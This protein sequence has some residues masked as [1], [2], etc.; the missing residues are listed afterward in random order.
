MQL[1]A[2]SYTVRMFTQNERDFA[3]TM[4]KIHEIGYRAVQLS[5]VGN[6]PIKTLRA[7][8]DDNALEIVLTHTAPDRIIG[9]ID[10]VIREHETLGCRYVGLG[11]MPDKYR[12]AAWI[13]HFSEDFLLSA[14]ALV[15]AGMKLMYHNHNFEWERLPSGETLLD[16]LLASMPAAL[17][18]VTLDT[19]WVQAAGADVYA[20]MD[21]LKDRL[22]CVHLKD[23]A[24]CGYTPRMAAVGR[25]NMDFS[26]ILRQLE[27]QG[28]TKYALVEQ[29]DCYG[30]NP[31]DCLRQS[32]DYIMREDVVK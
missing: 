31:F 22:D 25:G 9:D 23:M 32:Y 19:Y 4:R 18:G 16:R 6:I 20:V 12:G 27:A 3:R 13:D 29:D 2:Q 1:G 17:M 11:A 8:C 15:K 24:V 10:A 7:I 26:K 30:E 5:A 21:R 14:Q 28:T